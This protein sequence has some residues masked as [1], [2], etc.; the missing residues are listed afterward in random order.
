MPFSRKKSTPL[1]MRSSYC[2]VVFY[3]VIN[4]MA[5]TSE[6]DIFF[7]IIYLFIDQSITGRISVKNDREIV[8]FLDGFA[9]FGAVFKSCDIALDSGR[10]NDVQAVSV[11]IRR[12]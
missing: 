8:I 3:S 9:D 5:L 2:F 6:E 10:V 11:Y 7:L 4:L 1:P 12:F